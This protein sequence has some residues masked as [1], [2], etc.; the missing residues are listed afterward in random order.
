MM[1]SLND[2]SKETLFENC[3]ADVNI[4]VGEV[5]TSPKLTGTEG[6]LNVSEVYLNDLK[7]VDLTITFKDGKIVD[8]TCKTRNSA[9]CDIIRNC[10]NIYTC[11]IEQTTCK[12]IHII[13]RKLFYTEIFKNRFNAFSLFQCKASV[14][15]QLCKKVL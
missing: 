13:N 9:L 8:Y 1:Q 4:P 12:I 2:P 3:L 6:V 11:S 14:S 15:F 5:F 10:K 7:Y